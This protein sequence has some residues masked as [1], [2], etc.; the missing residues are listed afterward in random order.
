M[1]LGRHLL[2]SRNVRTPRPP[3]PGRVTLS[4]IKHTALRRPDLALHA[5][6]S[7]TL[8][9]PA[10]TVRPPSPRPDWLQRD[11]GEATGQAQVQRRVAQARFK[12]R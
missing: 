6:V 5:T 12:R 4:R 7:R 10:T 8:R 3:Q 11:E 2:N 1:P 9:G